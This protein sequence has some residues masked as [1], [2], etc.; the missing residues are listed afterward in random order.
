M[1]N[2][3]VLRIQFLDTAIFDTRGGV[4]FDETLHTLCAINDKSEIR[5]IINFN[6]CLKK[7]YGQT[8][9]TGVLTKWLLIVTKGRQGVQNMKKF[10][11]RTF[12]RPLT[13]IP[14]STVLQYGTVYCTIVSRKLLAMHIY[15]TTSGRS[16]YLF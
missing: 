6:E 5:N 14:I 1:N 15:H 9:L 11:F 12:D 7:R 3:I 16:S 13:S 8:S 4:Q 10:A 2:F